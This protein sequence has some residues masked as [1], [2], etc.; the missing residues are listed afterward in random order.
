MRRKPKQARS[1]QRVAHILKTAARLFAEEG[2]ESVSTNHIAKAADV[3][4]G[5]LYQFFPNK[6]AILDALVEDYLLDMQEAIL[7]KLDDHDDIRANISRMV[8]N[9]VRF[10]QSH[11]AFK[12]L[13]A[14]ANPDLMPRIHDSIV[15]LV[16]DMIDSHY[17]QLDAEQRRIGAEVGLGIVKGTMSVAEHTQCLTQSHLQ[18]ELKAAL[19]CY[20]HDLLKRNGIT[21][22]G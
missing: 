17:P 18:T 14:E 11:L 4:I 13:F 19:C 3:P 12:R 21:P 2:Y 8:D 5:S 7:G 9:M 20:I 1:Q 10:G 15:R 16:E 6:E 22:V